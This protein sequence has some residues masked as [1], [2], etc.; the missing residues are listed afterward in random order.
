MTTIQRVPRPRGELTSD[1]LRRLS[2]AARRQVEAD[3]MWR[4]EV[5]AVLSE[6]AS[7]SEVSKVTGLSTRTLQNW[8]KAAQ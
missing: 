3:A 5:V 4:A 2:K 7:F 6:G 8:K 1:Q